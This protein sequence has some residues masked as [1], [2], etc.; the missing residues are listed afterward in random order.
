MITVKSEATIAGISELRNKSEKILDLLKSHRVI[1]E[2]HRKP[3]AVMI[4][5]EEYE[6]FQK[7]IELADDYL[8]GKMSLNRDKTAKKNDFVDIE[9][10]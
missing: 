3:I 5:Y 8:L 10:W 6:K 2:R 4:N 7:I 9:K 1:L